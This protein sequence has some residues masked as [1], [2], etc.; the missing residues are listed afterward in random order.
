M[1]KKQIPQR[2]L[3]TGGSS[4]IGWSIAQKFS[5]EGSKVVV[6]DIEKPKQ[7]NQNILYKKCDISDPQEVA[8]LFSWTNEKIGDPDLLALDQEVVWIV[9]VGAGAGPD[10]DRVAAGVRLGE[11]EAELDVARGDAGQ[12]RARFQREVSVD[13]RRKEEARR[14]GDQIREAVGSV[15]QREGCARHQDRERRADALQVALHV[16]PKGQ[17][18]GHARGAFR[19]ASTPS[20]VLSVKAPRAR[21]ASSTTHQEQR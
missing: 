5:A 7:E 19:K 3:I 18:F 21:A 9:G 15:K 16:A 17:L 1:Q 2:V 11:R 4:G 14:N 10:L 12:D 8:H 20:S 13:H 6:A